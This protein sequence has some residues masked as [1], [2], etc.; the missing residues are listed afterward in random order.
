MQL[1]VQARLVSG[2]F[3]TPPLYRVLH[4]AELPLNLRPDRDFVTPGVPEVNTG[5]R[6]QTPFGRDWQLLTFAMNPGMTGEHWR[7]LYEYDTAFCNGTGFNKPG[8]PRADYVNLRDLSAR[9]PLWQNLTFCGG[10]VFTGTEAPPNLRLDMLDGFGPAPS[11]DWMLDHPWYFFD[12]ITVY[13]DGH[14]NRFPQGGGARVYVPLVGSGI[15]T[16]PLAKLQRLAPGQATDP[17]QFY[18]LV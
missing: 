4:D 10:T 7:V 17:Y 6:E 11:L 2:E 5:N 1:N 18:T 9:D 16:Y 13:K 14:L 15:A 3:N 8:S 12:A